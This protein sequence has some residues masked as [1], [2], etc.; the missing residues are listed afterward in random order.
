MGL[1]YLVIVRKKGKE[2]NRRVAGRIINAEESKTHV[3]FLGQA[4]FVFK[5]AAG[6]TIAVDLYLSDCAERSYGL[7]RLMPYLLDVDEVVFDYVITT[8]HH[9][10]HFDTDSIPAMLSNRNTNLFASIDCKSEV[11][12]LRIS[13]E[14]VT[15]I[16][17]GGR[18]KIG[19]TI[20]D[21]VFCDHGD[22]APDAVGLV[23]EIDGKKVYIAG[24]TALRLDKISEIVD[25]G[26][27]DLMIAPINGAFGNL[28]ES[29]AVTLCETIKPKL[30]IPCH[31]WNFAEHHGDPGLFACILEER[32]PNQNYYIMR[33]GESIIL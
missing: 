21:A 7:K 23:I 22:S 28:N 20:I 2:L 3:F 25:K 11:T 14:Q 32:L 30:I 26:P 13:D 27:F 18:Y 9:F 1:L 6:E 10:D 33:M 29:E 31:Y 19:S 17:K 12:K 24:D 4:G 16:K 5:T 15:Y 8:H